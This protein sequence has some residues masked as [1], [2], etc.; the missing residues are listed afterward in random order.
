[1]AMSPEPVPSARRTDVI[2]ADPK[3]IVALDFA[4]PDCGLDLVIGRPITQ[5]ADPLEALARIN[6]S[7]EVAA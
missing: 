5:A 4:D 2:Q 1:M 3:V 6:K 7:L